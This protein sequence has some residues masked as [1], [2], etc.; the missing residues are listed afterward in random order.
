MGEA[1]SSRGGAGHRGRGPRDYK[2]SDERIHDEVCERLTD[3][4]FV[5]ASDI[6]VEVADGEVTLS[7]TVASRDQKRRAES[8]LDRI[9]GVQDVHNR[10]RVQRTREATDQSASPQQRVSARS[11]GAVGTQSIPISTSRGNRPT[12]H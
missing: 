6:T 7:G 3:D 8:A 10:L 12:H 1:A 4:H 2:R 11:E 5:D 9:A